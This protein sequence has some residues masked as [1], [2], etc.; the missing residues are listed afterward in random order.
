M[1]ESEAKKKFCPHL[2]QSRAMMMHSLAITYINSSKT[3]EDDRSYK[4]TIADLKMNCIGSKCMM[5][6][7]WT[8]RETTQTEHYEGGPAADPPEGDGW[9][10]Y[11]APH[12]VTTHNGPVNIRIT[13]KRDVSI[14]HGV[15]GLISKECNQ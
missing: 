7:D 12:R 5:W 13:W 15:C 9:E 1:K 14:G 3:R 11:G 4:D 10:T 6:E 8:K 2:A